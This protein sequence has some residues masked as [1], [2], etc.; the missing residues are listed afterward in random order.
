LQVQRNGVAFNLN[1]PLVQPT[2]TAAGMQMIEQDLLVRSQQFLR[3][4]ATETTAPQALAATGM[5]AI[6]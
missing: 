1:R 6:W 4:H 5:S 2:M 3:R